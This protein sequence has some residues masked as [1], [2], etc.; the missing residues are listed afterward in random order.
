MSSG[1][2]MQA[3]LMTQGLELML[4]GMGTVVVFLSALVVATS[5]MSVLIERFFPEAPAQ[6]LAS[7]RPRQSAPT[8]D[9]SEL[10]AVISAAIQRHRRRR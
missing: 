3:D 8:A 4:Y 7:A 5:A 10:V 6:P 9:D 2:H 1:E